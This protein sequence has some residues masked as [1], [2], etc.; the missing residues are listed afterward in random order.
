M[1]EFFYIGVFLFIFFLG[2]ILRIL[3]EYRV[4]TQHVGNPWSRFPLKDAS[5]KE[6]IAALYS[7]CDALAH[8]HKHGIVHRAICPDSICVSHGQKPVIVN[9]GYARLPLDMVDPIVEFPAPLYLA[10][11]TS[12]RSDAWLT[13]RS[14]VWAMGLTAVSL[15]A[16][17][18]AAHWLFQS[19]AYAHLGSQDFIAS[20]LASWGPEVNQM[21]LTNGLLRLED[22]D[23][24]LKIL[25]GMLCV[26]PEER[27]T[28]QQAADQL[29][30]LTL[31]TQ[32]ESRVMTSGGEEQ[33]P[34]VLQQGPS[35][36]AKL[37][38]AM[39]LA[40]TA[41]ST[42]G[43]PKRKAGIK[44]S[45]QII[46]ELRTLIDRHYSRTGE[47]LS[48]A[49]FKDVLKQLNDAGIPL[50]CDADELFALLDE[51]N[52]N[53]VDKREFL[54]GLAILLSPMASEEERIQ[55]MFH[56]YDA[57]GNRTLSPD[58]VAR[59]LSHLEFRG[60]NH[61]GRNLHDDSLET[62]LF[63]SN[64]SNPLFARM[65]RDGDGQVTFR[66]FI[67]TMRSDPHMC[68]LVIDAQTFIPAAVDVDAYIKASANDWYAN[69]D[70]LDDMARQ[71]AE[72]DT[73][74]AYMAN[75]ARHSGAVAARAA[76]EAEAWRAEVERQ[77]REESDRRVA[78]AAEFQAQRKAAGAPS[79]AVPAMT[80]QESQGGEWEPV[81]HGRKKHA[82]ASAASPPLAT[83]VH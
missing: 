76:A 14:D 9:L 32:W 8:L 34:F 12:G 15:L 64:V 57:D 56:A 33:S 26:N 3:S 54:A 83:T 78:A 37:R 60:S 70:F 42:Q 38:K 30:Q 35:K 20:V 48:K 18:D 2:F 27:S 19:R 47:S 17:I 69:A 5:L 74:A 63:T 22:N 1:V 59:L 46:V 67:T 82:N 51:D 24:L 7:A 65:D 75:A 49:Q 11:E 77:Q 44:V 31:S 52:S 81:K 36:L 16:N 21:L 23:P 61:S 41:I 62:L 43:Q 71:K 53:S 40:K 4:A 80:R 50:S 6:K 45:G 73:I 79:N 29:F 72:E 58:E 10:P 39:Q 13:T 66:E 68:E 25:Q 55:M 28:A